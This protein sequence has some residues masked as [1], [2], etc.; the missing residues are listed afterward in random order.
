MQW[1]EAPHTIPL[2]VHLRLQR[3]SVA[4]RPHDAVRHA[5]L[6]EILL[7]LAKYEDAA[8]AFEEAHALDSINFRHIDRLAECYLLLDRPDDA[9]RVCERG[10]DVMPDSADFHTA[11]GS[12]LRALGRHNE[13]HYTFL[14]ALTVGPDAFDAAECLLAPL[15][16]H[17]DAARLLA[18]CE[19]FPSTYADSTVVRGYRA[20]GLSRAGYL[21]E[22]RSLVDL[23]KYP[24]R[25]MI[26]PPPEFKNIEHFN[27]M[28]AD[29]ILHSPGLRYTSNYKFHRTEFLNIPGA[30]AYRSLAKC[31]CA[32]IE[33]YM[34]EFVQRG[35]DKTLS[36]P[37]REGRL[38]SA[39]NVV[40]SEEGHRA[41]LHKYAYISGVYY[42][43]VPPIRAL[44]DDRAGALVLG[45][46]DSLTDGYVPCWGTRDVKPV[47]GVAVL[48]P[49]NIFHSVLP[50]RTDHPRV[51]VPFDLCIA[52]NTE[53]SRLHSMP[54]ASTVHKQ[55]Q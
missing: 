6:G 16:S 25:I 47:P 23:D 12:A 44:T 46:C 30:R 42:V 45:C 53:D 4:R 50:T 14:R 3:E 13:A 33:V 37:P 7:Q 9:L 41:H 48:F 2:D 20:I 26:E 5:K 28:L 40:R 39:G 11:H 29:E 36:A 27:A 43:A 38:M 22:A 24:A 19:E 1:M 35:L 32:A 34:S 31:L 21:D 52:Q 54:F 8:A 17:P 10:I 51:A 18:L 55:D 15:A 49:S